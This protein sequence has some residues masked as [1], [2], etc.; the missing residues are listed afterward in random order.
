MIEFSDA[1]EPL[2]TLPGVRAAFL[3]RMPGIAVDADREATL[4]RLKPVHD[5]KLAALGFAPPITAEQVHGKLVAVIDAATPFPLA[6]ADGLATAT[7]GLT[8][9][10]YVADCAAI[11]LVDSNPK[12]RA[13]ALVHS[14]KKG[15]E[16]NILG[17]AVKTL[18]ANFGTDPADLVAVV[19][20]CIRPPHYEIDFAATIAAQAA[21][22]GI[23]NF[24]DARICT[25]SHP[26]RYYS[27]RREKGRTGRMLA[28][29]AL[30]L[31]AIAV[32]VTASAPHA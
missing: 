18:S 8:L 6:G 1:E 28:L 5:A 17:E 29:L 7:P 15:T 24:H 4:V 26:D 2:D 25:A 10:I 32:D 3:G 14:G 27:Y 23:R 20:P 12:N 13:I 16:Q 9:G 19:S 11:W 31:P 21:E 22:A 30:E